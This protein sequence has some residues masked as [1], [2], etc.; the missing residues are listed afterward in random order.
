MTQSPKNCTIWVE[1][2]EGSDLAPYFG[3]WSQIEKPFEIKPPLIQQL[4][5]VFLLIVLVGGIFQ[6]KPASSTLKI[7]D[8]EYPPSKII[9]YG[10]ILRNREL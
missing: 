3:D 8:S 4:F 9:I 2:A 7:W 10:K 1:I 5:F 6:N